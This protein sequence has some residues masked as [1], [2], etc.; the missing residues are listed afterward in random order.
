MDVFPNFYHVY[1]INFYTFGL[2]YL[3]IY[4][5]IF[6]SIFLYIYKYRSPKVSKVIIHT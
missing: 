1:I 4:F 3:Y 2:L 6:V 5:H